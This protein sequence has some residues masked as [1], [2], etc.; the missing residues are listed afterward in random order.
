MAPTFGTNGTVVLG[1]VGTKPLASFVLPDGKILVIS[2]R[3]TKAENTA[4][5]RY[6]LTRLNANGTPDTT[7]DQNGVVTLTGLQ[8]NQQFY[9]FYNCNRNFYL[10]LHRFT[11]PER[12]FARDGIRN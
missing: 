8:A 11:L 1:N 9:R 6:H 3:F 4:P 10:R 12:R 2:E 7:Y 5:F